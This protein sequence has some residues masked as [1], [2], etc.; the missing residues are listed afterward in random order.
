M[1]R[2]FNSSVL[3]TFLG[4]M[5]FASLGRAEDQ[6]AQQ[7]LKRA[8]NAAGGERNL[9]RLKGAT[10][11]MERGT[12]YG[13]GDGVPYVGQYASKWPKWYRQEIEN[14][15]AITASGNNAWVTSP[16]GVQRLEG[17]R[18]AEQIKQVQAAWAGR[19]FPL[20]DKAYTLTKIDGMTVNG[21]ST[22]GIEASHRQHGAM[23]FYFDRETHLI[24]KIENMVISPQHGPEPVLSETFVTEHKSFA[25]IT[26]PSKFKLHYDKK[27]F[28][29]GETVDYKTGATLDAEKFKAPE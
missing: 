4:L 19:L 22:V 9:E 6:E 7:I 17:A 5:I 27:L 20:K 1:L 14:A 11:W 21:R 13:M 25:G 2:T 8:M 18:L 10:M 3:I 16:N 24:A 26:L 28:V 23:K 15:F 12:F 29:E